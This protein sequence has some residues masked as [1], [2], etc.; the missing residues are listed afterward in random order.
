[1]SRVIEICL[2]MGSFMT[3]WALSLYEMSV[4]RSF[5]LRMCSESRSIEHDMYVTI[6]THIILVLRLLDFRRNR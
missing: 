6:D 5:L 2:Y 3:R 4:T 1:M